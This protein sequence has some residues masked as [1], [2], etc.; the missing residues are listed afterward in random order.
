MVAESF[1][2]PA[3][4]VARGTVAVPGSKSM[5]QRY[6]NLALIGRAP[7]VIR[8]PLLSEDPRLFLDALGAVGFDVTITS[9]SVVRLVPGPVPASA[10]IFCGNGGTMFRFLTAALT[11]VPG[12]WRLDGVPRLRERPVTPLVAAVRRLGANIDCPE[13]PGHAPLQIRGGTLEGGVTELDAGASS[14]YLSALLMAALAAAVPTEVMVRTLTSAPYV[15]LTLAAIERFG[16]AVAVDLREDGSRCYRVVPA[17]LDAG[18]V[19]VEG[20]Y[21]AAA[22]PAAAAALTG[23][24]VRIRGLERGSRQGDRQ[25]LD[26]LE[27]MGARVRWEG[28]E[29]VIEAGSLNAVDI[30][31]SSMPDQVPTLAALAPFARGTTRIRNVA[32]LRIKESDRIFAMAEE[33]RKAGAAVSE[34]ADG[35]EVEGCWAKTAPPTS[36]VVINTHGDHRIAMAMALVGLRRPGLTIS[37]PDVVAKSY[38]DFW[39]DLEQLLVV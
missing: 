36:P 21:S 5:T 12:S 38:P 16:G 2:V 13:Q 1:A 39:N 8:R 27:D 18:E 22:Y 28:D 3:G 20:D 23:G 9:D 31:L 17:R 15:G 33:L 26:L 7:L 11:T 35:L 10:R 4:K 25:F 32:H 6:L 24:P 29:P 37:N 19:V 30:D 14:Q 34:H